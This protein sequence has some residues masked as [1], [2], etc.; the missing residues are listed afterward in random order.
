MIIGSIQKGARM[1][2]PEKT[3][4]VLH[5]SVGKNVVNSTLKDEALNQIRTKSFIRIGGDIKSGIDLGECQEYIPARKLTVGD[6]ILMPN[7][8]FLTIRMILRKTKAGWHCLVSRG[9]ELSCFLEIIH[10]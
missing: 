7:K 8:T 2:F 1:I 6:K 5:V 10:S 3:L 4:T 9:S